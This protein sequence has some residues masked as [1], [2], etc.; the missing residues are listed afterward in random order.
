MVRAL[1]P[2]QVANQLTWQ[3]KG[4][5]KN[6]QLAY[7]RVAARLARIRDQELWKALGHRSIEDYAQKR[8]GQQRAMLGRIK[9]LRREAEKEPRFPAAARAALDHA[10]R[11]LEQALGASRQVAKLMGPVSIALARRALEGAPVVV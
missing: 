5:L 9:A 11:A 7:V 8:L 2:A 10:V 3:L 6:I 4:D 1:S